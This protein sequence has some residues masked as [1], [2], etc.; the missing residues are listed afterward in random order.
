MT[1]IPTKVENKVM[2]DTTP[3]MKTCNMISGEENIVAFR[4]S[5]LKNGSSGTSGHH[6]SNTGTNFIK[7]GHKCFFIVHI[8]FILVE[9]EQ[10]DYNIGNY[11]DGTILTAPK[12]GLYSF[13]ATL[14]HNKGSCNSF[15]FYYVNGKNISNTYTGCDNLSNPPMQATLKLEKD[16]KVEVRF[17][18]NAFGTDDQKGTFFEGRY[19]SSIDD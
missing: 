17:G 16:D 18:G 12:A 13:L 11:F 15:A 7:L 4:A 14:Q 2:A 9:W 3:D 5:A 10:I 6:S 1:T 8:I 19:I